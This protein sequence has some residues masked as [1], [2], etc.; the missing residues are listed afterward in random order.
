MYDPLKILFLSVAFTTILSPL[1]SLHSDCFWRIKNA[2]VRSQVRVDEETGVF[3]YDV[4]VWNNNTGSRGVSDE[5]S[6]FLWYMPP[7]E[8]RNNIPVPPL[9]EVPGKYTIDAPPSLGKDYDPY[10]L[11]IKVIGPVRWLNRDR[12]Y[13]HN[14]KGCENVSQDW[15]YTLGACFVMWTPGRGDGYW[16]EMLNISLDALYPGESTTFTIASYGLP[17][18]NKFEIESTPITFD[19][20]F[21]KENN[22]ENA[23]AEDV[24]LFMKEHGCSDHDIDYDNYTKYVTYVV[25]PT[26]P[27]ENFDI[28]KFIAKI[29]NKY[30]NWSVMSGWINCEDGYSGGMPSPSVEFK[31]SITCPDP[32]HCNISD[33]RVCGGIEYNLNDAYS[34]VKSGD[35]QGAIVS[36]EKIRDAVRSYGCS[37]FEGCEPGKRIGSEAYALLYYNV[38]FAIDYLTNQGSGPAPPYFHPTTK[39][40]V[41]S[42]KAE[43]LSRD[44]SESSPEGQDKNCGWWCRFK[45]WWK[46][47]VR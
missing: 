23:S 28:V 15:C 32:E 6:L 35:T 14:L 1:P 29:H 34:K 16:Y 31:S 30:F 41:Q 42:H 5:F 20:N 44:H 39:K 19:E 33:E 8:G 22:L 27:P 12:C 36:L 2:K 9:E 37:S 45:R 18:I 17:G 3:L 10:C 4:K 11:P 47:L 43:Q 13:Q 26:A 38:S 40:Q 25:S 7:I 46:R 21:F 24:A